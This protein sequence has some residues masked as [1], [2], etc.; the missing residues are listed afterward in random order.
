MGSNVTDLR[1][2]LTELNPCAGG[3]GEALRPPVGGLGGNVPQSGFF[4]EPLLS[5]KLVPFGLGQSYPSS[6]SLVSYGYP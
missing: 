3:L 6:K 5:L 1:N 2:Q 4:Q